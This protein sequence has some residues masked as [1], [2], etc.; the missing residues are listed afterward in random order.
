MCETE[1]AILF[2]CLSLSKRQNFN[3]SKITAPIHVYNP[4][5]VNVMF[6]EDKGQFNDLLDELG[7][8]KLCCR[9]HMLGHVDLIKT[10]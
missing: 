1:P 6:I 5:S 9:R 3:E 7:I 8:N 4:F 10:I 2:Q